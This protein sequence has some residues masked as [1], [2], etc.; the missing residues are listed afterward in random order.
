MRHFGTTTLALLCIEGV[1]DDGGEGLLSRPSSLFVAMGA[2]VR[3][4]VIGKGALIRETKE[5]D[6]AKVVQLT[7]ETIVWG[8]EQGQSQ[9]GIERRVERRL[10]LKQLDRES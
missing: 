6:S 7:P 2:S 10:S 3:L 9:T 8:L 4:R 5:L 1:V